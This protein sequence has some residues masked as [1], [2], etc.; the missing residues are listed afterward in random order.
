[1]Y[2][3]YLQ[4]LTYTPLIKNAYFL[5]I[6]TLILSFLFLTNMFSNIVSVYVFIFLLENLAELKPMTRPG[7]VRIEHEDL[8]RS[9]SLWTAVALSGIQHHKT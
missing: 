4:F 8:M 2:L 9:T 1:M 5:Y 6:F 3:F 7:D